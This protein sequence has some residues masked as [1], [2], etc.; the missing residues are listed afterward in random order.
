MSIRERENEKATQKNRLQNRYKHVV[1]RISRIS[2]TFF[3][4]KPFF[5]VKNG[6]FTS[7]RKTKPG[8]F[9]TDLL[10]AAHLQIR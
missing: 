3:I 5:S 10:E 4:V 8:I 7:Q 6:L 9:D 1:N 2:N